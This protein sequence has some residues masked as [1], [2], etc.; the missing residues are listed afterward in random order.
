VVDMNG[1]YNTVSRYGN[2]IMANGDTTILAVGPYKC[3][4]GTCAGSGLMLAI[5][6]LTSTRGMVLIMEGFTLQIPL[7]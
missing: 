6:N 1:L 2:S 3:S 4:E 7:D 5:D